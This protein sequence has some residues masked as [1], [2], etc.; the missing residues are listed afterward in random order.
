MD[1]P[2]TSRRARPD[3]W[4]RCVTWIGLALSACS[5][6]GRVGERPAPA[7]VPEVVEAASPL[8]ALRSEVVAALDVDQLDEALEA[9]DGVLALTPD[10][11]RAHAMR[12]V[13]LSFQERPAEAAEAWAAALERAPDRNDW[14]FHRLQALF[15]AG[16]Y[17][18][19]AE[20]YEQLWT[21]DLSTLDASAVHPLVHEHG[22]W[23]EAAAPGSLED[24]GFQGWTWLPP[25][26]VAGLKSAHDLGGWALLYT[27]HLTGALR[28]FD[29]MRE[30]VPWDYRGHEG[31]GW[32][33]ALLGRESA[34]AEAYAHARELQPEV[35][36]LRREIGFEH[37]RHG[38]ADAAEMCFELARA[39]DPQV[40]AS[41][42]S[43]GAR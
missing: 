31:A 36:R 24:D 26:R 37:Q 27:G 23:S 41:G 39:L 4:A 11:A 3:R 10:D 42:E 13:L 6:P 16:R 17:E 19:A 12:G 28:A 40:P 21:T 1:A 18:A 33:L 22:A 38:R 30:Y 9:V 8:D 20:E 32:A 2:G 43:F 14:R 29:R 35:A 15:S 25:G 7:P 34:A 5:T